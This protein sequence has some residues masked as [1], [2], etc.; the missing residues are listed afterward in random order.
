MSRETSLRAVSALGVVAFIAS[1]CATGFG[2]QAVRSERPDYNQQIVRSGDAEM[3]LNLVRLRYND[4]PLFLEL[5]TV[6]AT[7]GYDA[8]FNACR[9]HSEL[10]HQHRVTGDGPDVCGAPDHHLR[11]AGGRQIR[12]PHAHTHSIGPVHAR[13]EWLE[14]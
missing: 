11:A 14:R 3:L 6:V 2:P 8:S 10:G 9:H 12:H 7:Y 1:G 4:T 13:P 5:G